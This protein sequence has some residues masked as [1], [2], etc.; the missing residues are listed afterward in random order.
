MA[1][2]DYIENLRNKFIGKKVKYEGS[3]YTIAAV[4]Y[5]GVI[6]IDKPSQF[7]ETTAVYDAY[8]AELNLVG[9]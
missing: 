4:D 1:Y 8:E 2:R 3:E 9:A 6:H 7:T 5:N